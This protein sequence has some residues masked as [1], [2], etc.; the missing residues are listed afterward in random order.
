VPCVFD[1][2]IATQ[3][4]FVSTG[5]ILV[6]AAA[7][8]GCTPLLDTHPPLTPGSHDVAELARERWAFSPS[9][10]QGS[11]RLWLLETCGKI[12]E[13]GEVTMATKLLR[14]EQTVPL[15]EITQSCGCA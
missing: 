10:L 15:D 4:S 7:L 13:S 11:L 14:S 3:A 9:H 2:V 6:F 8:V 12:W 5:T 1:E